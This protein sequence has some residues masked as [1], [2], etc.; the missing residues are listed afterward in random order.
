MPDGLLPRQ[1]VGPNTVPG[2]ASV[3]TG[4]EMVL[5]LE[6]ALRGVPE[7]FPSKPDPGL[8]VEWRRCRARQ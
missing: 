8:R 3:G 1:G 7:V 6:V 5:H 2:P 4:F